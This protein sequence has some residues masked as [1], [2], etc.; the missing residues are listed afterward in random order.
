M[1][2]EGDGFLEKNRDTLAVDVVGALRLAE[3]MLLNKLYGGKASEDGRSGGKGRGIS[4]VSLDQL[5]CNDFIAG[6]KASVGTAKSRM[7]QSIKHARKEIQ[8]KGVKTV[9]AIFKSSLLS[10]KDQL[11][12]SQP[13]FIRCV[14]PN[15]QKQAGIFDDD[16]VLKQLR[17]RTRADSLWYKIKAL[18]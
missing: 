10:L 5:K 3:N 15:H 12:A 13:H 9:C 16:L 1:A 6:R 8:K 14:K 7:R 2:Y 17:Y 18:L 4:T 11:L